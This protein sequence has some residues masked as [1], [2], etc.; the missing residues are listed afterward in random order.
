MNKF[1][2]KL[3]KF[4]EG[5]NGVDKLTSYLFVLYVIVGLIRTFIKN[6]IAGYV[7]SSAMVVIFLYAV[8]RVFSKNLYARHKENND[9]CNFLRRISPHF[10]LLKDR[11]KD[12]RTKRYRRCPHCRNILRL[13][14]KRGKHNVRCPKCGG[15]FDVYIL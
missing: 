6:S 4:M 1:R 8:F 2:Y 15:S 14:Y 9:F 10:I 11:I 7:V 3:M 13:P 5:R 12:I